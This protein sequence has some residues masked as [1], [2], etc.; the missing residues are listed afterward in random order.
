MLSL[1]LFLENREFEKKLKICETVRN[2]EDFLRHPVKLW[3]LR[4]L[5]VRIKQFVPFDYSD[6]VCLPNIHFCC[7]DGKKDLTEK[8]LFINLIDHIKVICSLDNTLNLISDFAYLLFF[9]L[10][11]NIMSMCLLRTCCCWLHKGII[12]KNT[13]CEWHYY[14]WTGHSVLTTF[15]QITF[16][17]H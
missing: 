11:L 7:L 2:E 9:F 5:D 16:L 14:H 13:S 1:L 8:N 4:G 15:R 10:I 3:E 6:G 17:E 12:N